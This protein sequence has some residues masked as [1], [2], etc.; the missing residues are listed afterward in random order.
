MRVGVGRG[1]PRR[2]LADHVLARFDADEQAPMAEAI[3]RAADAAELFLVEGIGPV[4]SRYNR[5]AD[6]AEE[7]EP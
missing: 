5:K 2:D 6:L 3:E 4:M 1:D 7:P